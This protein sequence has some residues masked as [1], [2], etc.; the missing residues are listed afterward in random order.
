MSDRKQLLLDENDIKLVLEQNRDNIGRKPLFGFDSLV[1]SIGFLLTII[2]TD[3]QQYIV[4]QYL[5]SILAIIYFMWG[6]YN[7]FLYHKSKSF[8]KDILFQQ[9]EDINL[10]ETHPHSIIL[11]KD[12]FNENP[13]RFLVYYDTRWK[14]KLFVNYHTSGNSDAEN[15]AN[16]TQHIQ[17]ELKTSPQNCVYLF[18][19]LHSKYSISAKRDKYYHHKFY[20]LT[21]SESDITRE[22]N[23]TI[24]GKEYFWMSIAQMEKDKNIMEKNRDIVSFVKEANV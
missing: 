12:D 18:D 1:A 8:N 19:K 5:L 15:I 20:R 21:M 16:I 4:L 13:N 2:F 6:I 3:F 22:D 23:F 10:M 17:T 11:I 9:L 7:I 14:C 24:D